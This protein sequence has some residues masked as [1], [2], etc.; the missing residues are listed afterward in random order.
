MKKFPLLAL[1]VF[2]ALGGG[3]FPALAVEDDGSKITITG[4]K[5]GDTVGETFP[6][7]YDLDKGS[8]AAHA[9]VYLDGKYQKGFD[10]TFKDVSKGQHEITVTAATHDHKLLA[11]TQTISVE[12]KGEAKS[13]APY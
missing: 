7:T 12:V 9:H 6:L 5:N 3:A 13:E 4:P 10:G 1:I 11:A 2:S 8:K